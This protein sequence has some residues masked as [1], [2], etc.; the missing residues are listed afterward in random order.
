[1]DVFAFGPAPLTGLGRTMAAVMSCGPDAL[2]S[3]QTAAA[4]WQLLPSA[5]AV[6]DVS[7]PGRGPDRRPGIVFHRRRNLHPD[8]CADCDGIPVTS[9]ARTLLDLAAVVPARRLRRAF[10]EAERLRL[11][12]GRRLR[13]LLDRHPRARGRRAFRGLLEEGTEPRWTRSELERRFVDFCAEAGLAAPMMN[14]LVEGYEVDAH[15]PGRALVVELDGF[16]THGT[17]KCFESDRERDAVLLTAGRPV[18]RVTQRRLERDA[19]AL[20][21]QL[22]TLLR[23]G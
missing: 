19:A 18:L 11:Y 15:W 20:R 7:A 8:D 17:R 10:E 6:F 14:G 9:V 16:A 23:T 4:L 1:V 21:A 3:H 2:A 12:D 22:R 13:E 5:R